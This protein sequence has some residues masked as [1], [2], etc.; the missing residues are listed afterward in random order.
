M[1]SCF[2]TPRKCAAPQHEAK[3]TLRPSPAGVFARGSIRFAR[4]KR[5]NYRK[6]TD[7]LAGND[8]RGVWPKPALADLG[9]IRLGYR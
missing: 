3:N 4:R 6:R 9:S 5:N 7:C 2:E 1:P 8:G